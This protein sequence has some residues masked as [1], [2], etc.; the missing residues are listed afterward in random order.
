MPADLLTGR[1]MADIGEK[2]PAQHV[3][4]LR[5]NLHR[6]HE[7]ARKRLGLAISNQKKTYDRKLLEKTFEKGDLVYLLGGVAKVGESRKLQEVYSGPFLVVDVL[8]PILYRIEGKKGKRRQVVHH[9]RLRIC[10]DRDVP[11]W[12]RR[13]QQR[14]LDDTEI[15]DNSVLEAD[16]E[17]PPDLSILFRVDRDENTNQQEIDQKEIDPVIS[18]HE[19]N[20]IEVSARGRIRK[21][22]GWQR[23]YDM[24]NTAP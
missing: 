15:Q 23:D 8:S 11:L 16:S 14:V 20:K 3:K 22:P 10:K 1:S 6:I 2:D 4:D 19:E 21:K 24:T 17:D 18:Q 12:A 9:D 7:L 5:D 13:E